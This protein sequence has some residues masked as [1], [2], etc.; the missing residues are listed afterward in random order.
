MIYNYIYSIKETTYVSHE[1]LDVKS[2]LMHFS[3]IDQCPFGLQ[4]E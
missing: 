2:I 4:K 1:L 3:N